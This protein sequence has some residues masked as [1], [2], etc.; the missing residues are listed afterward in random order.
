[1]AYCWYNN[2]ITY[3]DVYGPLYNW[4]TVSSGKL[5]P[6]G[7]HVP[8]ET[9]FMLLTT[10]IGGFDGGGKKL[11][12]TGTAHWNNPNTDATN[13]FGFTA[14]PGGYTMGGY[15]FGMGDVTLIWTSTETDNS[16]AYEWNISRIPYFVR[17]D[18]TKQFGASVR[19]LK[20]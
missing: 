11:K 10:Y 15:F 18:L 7:W 9:E 4:Y 2:D 8:S 14:L 20:D 13:E 12:E 19:C 5:C 3:K 17:E 6:K 16:N 1:M